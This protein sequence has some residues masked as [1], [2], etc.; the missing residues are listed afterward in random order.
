MVKKGVPVPDTVRYKF[1]TKIIGDSTKICVAVFP[2]VRAGGALHRVVSFAVGYS[3]RDTET[4]LSM[5]KNIPN[6]VLASGDWFRIAVNATG[7]YKISVADFE[8][9]G[10]P[11]RG[12]SIADIA[13]FGNGGGPLPERNNVPRLTDLAENAI[14][15]SDEN[16][17]GIF[18]NNDYI[19][20]YAEAANVWRYNSNSQLFE[21]VVHPYSTENYYFFTYTS[22]IGSGKRIANIDGNAGSPTSRTTSYTH[23]EVINND[24]VNT[25]NSGQIWVGERF[26]SSTTSRSFSLSAPNMVPG[27][28]IN[29]RYSLASIST[30]NSSFVVDWGYGSNTVPFST[31]TTPYSISSN[32]IRSAGGNSITFNIT[33]NCREGLATGYLD[34][35]E[36]N[37]ISQLRFRQGQTFFRNLS[38]APRGS[39]SR[40]AVAGCNR[41]V[42]LWDITDLTNAKNITGTFGNDTFYFNSEADTLHEYIA[43]D[44]SSFNAP[45][46]ITSL[47][48]Q[49]LH[50]LV[51]V[52][53][54]IVSHNAFLEQA[55]RIADL[56]RVYD[57]LSVEVVTPEQVYNEFSSGKQD[58]GAIRSLMKML[59]DKSRADAS[60]SAPRY[61]LLFGKA[62]YDNRNLLQNNQNT[63]VTYESLS[64]FDD[65][66]VSY[67]TDDFFGYLHDN[68]S[69]LST[70]SVDIGIGRLPARTETEARNMADKI[71]RYI[72]RKDF[73]IPSI[74]GDWRNSIVFIA[75]DAD[76]GS[77]G[78]VDFLLSSEYTTEKIKEQF[79]SFNIEK[80]YADSYVQQSGAIGSF[81]PDAKNA[82]TKSINYGC[83]LLNYVGHGA[84]G[85]IGSEHYMDISDIEAYT[86]KYALP[87]FMASTCT[88]G[89]FDMT[90]K[91]SGG[92][93]FVLSPNG[94]GIAIVA[95]S[96]P[97]SHS[98]SFD[99]KIC[100]EALRHSNGR[101]NTIG[102]ALMYAK[103]AVPSPHAINLIGDPALRL[104]LPEKNI[105][106]T[107]I[108]D[109]AVCDSIAD[110]ANVL[111]EITIEGEIR[112]ANGS[113]DSSFN[114]RLYSTVFDRVATYYTLANDNEDTE[115]PFTQ[116]KNVL[117][118]SSDTVVGGR[119]SYTFLVPKDVSFKYDFGKLSHYAQS[120][121]HNA[122]GCYKN[123]LFGG[124]N[125]D[126][127]STVFRPV[128]RLFMNDSLFLSGG[129]TNEN[130]SLYAALSD[131]VGI[132]SVG[133]G[134]GH[135][136]TAILDGNANEI[137]VL[138]D[139]FET[140]INDNT[141][142][143]IR[144]PLY[145]LAEGT[146]TLTLKAWNVYNYSASAT[147][148]FVVK[149]GSPEIG[150]FF[151]Y[152]NPAREKVTIQ[153]EHNSPSSP[154][155][156]EIYIFDA[157]GRMVRHITPS[158]AKGSFVAGLAEWDFCNQSGG[159]VANG[160]Y[161]LR[162]IVTFDNGEQDT[163]STKVIFHK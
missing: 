24:L 42:R 46:R 160:V 138:N 66:G 91:L 117:A 141:R 75:D 51:S 57:G 13:I 81:Y 23:C 93:K 101:Q 120:D 48:N 97:I 116:Q 111:S 39:I 27:S 152:P 26:S 150:R 161:Y 158:V 131:K 135:D 128:V 132:N 32:T 100:I 127:D 143:Y 37:A 122:T 71:E 56:H 159:K 89:K 110:T 14:M 70:E 124:F 154:I 83:L 156:A 3:T 134:I 121:N 34:F 102:D 4:R 40:M 136:I 16:N 92:E 105:T 86:N 77:P 6:S 106:V 68:E 155:A 41:N 22:G 137:F 2:Y 118:K 115:T 140:D 82:L 72:M 25:H 94:G 65:D 59:F 114:G 60:A 85:N 129:C 52:D 84:Y 53:L 30:Q 31:Y 1:Y 10:V 107:K 162:A 63:V 153:I 88:F 133:S 125:E 148:T 90:D 98:R 112:N 43:F 99:T 62:S 104:S 157:S 19:L 146:H 5:Q 54:V 130:P 126:A 45:L 139:F 36:I 29:V 49:N 8:G 7:I 35:I 79:P 142:G 144:Y 95:A 55:E 145:N 163:K 15:V 80:I 76:P 96:R 50:A 17:D 74:K 20:F 11:V 151:A 12:K 113:M 18:N 61:L 69:G 38:V 78:D 44:G 123:I 67:A 149:K 119:F 87:F 108:N 73:E 147:I 9:Y 109:K 21:Y 47:P 64:S 33:Y 103:N 58:A 28:D